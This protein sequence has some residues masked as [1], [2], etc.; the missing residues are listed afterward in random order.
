MRGGKEAVDVGDQN[1]SGFG[2]VGG[3]D[4]TDLMK[5]VQNA[6]GAGVADG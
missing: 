2:A 5:F 3:A 6:G 4:N 1:V